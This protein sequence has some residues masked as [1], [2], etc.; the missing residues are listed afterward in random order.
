MLTEEVLYDQSSRSWTCT[1]WF[2]SRLLI[3][4]NHDPHIQPSLTTLNHGQEE[5]GGEREED[6]EEEKSVSASVCVRMRI[7][8]RER[9]QERDGESAGERDKEKAREKD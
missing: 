9:V 1:D 2:A 4:A 7:D 6:R 5:K 3:P 8:W